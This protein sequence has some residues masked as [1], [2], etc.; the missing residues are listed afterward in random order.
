MEQKLLIKP[1]G[2][3]DGCAFA[4]VFG[5][6][7]RYTCRKKARASINLGT[8]GLWLSDCQIVS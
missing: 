3:A 4:L 6:D 7:E 1:F 8:S 2:V 5:V